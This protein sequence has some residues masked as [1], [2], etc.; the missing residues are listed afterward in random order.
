MNQSQRDDLLIE[1][2]KDVA[3]MKSQIKTLFAQQ[4]ANRADKK[5]FITSVTAVLIAMFSVVANGF[6]GM[7][8]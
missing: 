6:F 3:G 4:E 8:K 2:A 7:F 5:S 1:M